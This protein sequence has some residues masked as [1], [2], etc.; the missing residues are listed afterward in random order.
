MAD[1]SLSEKRIGLLVWQVSNH[2]QS[3][4]RKIL[5]NFNLSLNEYLILE[6]LNYIEKNFNHLSTQTNISDFSGIDV[7]VVSICL[8]SLEIK[9]YIKKE[10]DKDIRKKN[11][12]ILNEG[13]KIFSVIYPNINKQEREIF[14]KLENEKYNFSN[15]LKLV[16]GKKLRIKAEK[17]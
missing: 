16:L 14:E 8:K 2:W 15:S 12:K 10:V 9:K 5:K 13:K 1:T 7:S 3:K 17:I 4:M 6:S 11:I